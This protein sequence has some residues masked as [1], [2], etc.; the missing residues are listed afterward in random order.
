MQTIAEMS[1]FTRR[2]EKILGLTERQA[3]IGYLAES[4]KAGV[5][6]QGT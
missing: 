4:P 2:A 3:L 5:L 1:E 6:M